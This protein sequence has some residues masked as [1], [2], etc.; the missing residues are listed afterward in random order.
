MTRVCRTCKIEFE[1]EEWKKQC[2]ACYKDFK[3]EPRIEQ[4]RGRGVAI[5]A[6]PSCTKEEINEWIKLKY[7][8]VND[9]SNWG[10][11]EMTGK[12][13]RLWWNSQNDD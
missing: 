5:S 6:H 8:S 10:A 9:P 7:G 11:V 4:V 12:N 1:G 2:Y 3:G 13:R